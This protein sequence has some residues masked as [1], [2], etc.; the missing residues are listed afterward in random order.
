MQPKSRA[1]INGGSRFGRLAKS[2]ASIT[3]PKTA[4]VRHN[5]IS[6]QPHRANAGDAL[7][8]VK[9]Q[10]FDM[11]MKYHKSDLDYGQIVQFITDAVP[12]GDAA[13]VNMTSKHSLPYST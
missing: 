4:L 3:Y 7:L 5:S 12:P 2:K 1:G 8:D 6:L 10:A 9:R 11:M 13:T